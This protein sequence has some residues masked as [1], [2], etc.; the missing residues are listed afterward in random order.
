MVFIF[1]LVCPEAIYYSMQNNLCFSDHFQSYHLL[2]LLVIVK[3]NI[4]VSAAFVLFFRLIHVFIQ[5]PASNCIF[6]LVSVCCRVVN[7]C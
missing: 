7:Y 4:P 5:F 1:I 6:E 3:F 2:L